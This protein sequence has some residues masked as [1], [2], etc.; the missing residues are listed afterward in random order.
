MSLK[1]LTYLLLLLLGVS[2]SPSDDGPEIKLDNMLHIGQLGFESSVVPKGEYNLGLFLMKSDCRSIRPEQIPDNSFY[3]NIHDYIETEK[4]GNVR[5][6]HRTNSTDQKII[7]TLILR[8]RTFMF[9]YS[10]FLKTMA[11]PSS[12]NNA[13]Y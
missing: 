2:C 7:D 6:E 8:E 9:A 5:L 12:T 3:F 1:K 11:E 13:Y 4:G 10:P